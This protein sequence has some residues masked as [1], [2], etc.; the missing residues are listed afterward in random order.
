MTTTNT[1]IFDDLGLRRVSDQ[2]SSRIPKKEL[3]Q[4]DFLK[5]L[6]TQL[7]NQDPLKPLDNNEFIAQMAQFSSVDSLQKLQG[8]FE[9]LS[10]SLT[11]NQALQ[12]SAL[13]GRSVLVNGNYGYLSDEQGIG[14]YID[15]PR[16]AENIKITIE[17]SA[18]VVVREQS[19][20]QLDAGEQPFAWDGK[21]SSGTDLPSGRYRIVVSGSV[22][23]KTET[24][25]TQFY[26]RVDS[27]NL[28]RNGEG[29]TLNLAGM[30]KVPL[31][32]VTQIG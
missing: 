17:N 2:Q 4:D 11:S 23:G 6:T 22:G 1:S 3:S 16:G 32:D 29:I 20:P 27:V 8:S 15:V 13:V 24:F 14:G 28:G 30:G 19:V 31:A 21:D 5:L 10:S 9:T 25:T 12:A 18:G 26:A 7:R